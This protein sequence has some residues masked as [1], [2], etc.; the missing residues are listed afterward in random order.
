MTIQL[1]G[2]KQLD[3][4]VSTALAPERVWA[5]LMDARLLPRWAGP[6]DRIES[7]DLEG[8]RVGTVRDCRVHLGGRAGRIVERCVGLIPGQAIAY[9]VDDD[10]FGMSRM[11]AHYSFMISTAAGEAGATRLR[12]ETYYTPRNACASVMNALV[13]RRRFRGVVDELLAGLVRFAA[14]YE[15]SAQ[16]NDSAAVRHGVTGVVPTMNQ[17]T[18]KTAEE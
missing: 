4:E 13:L 10:S 15:P 7:C 14:E 2:T 18:P 11:L 9:A 3:R 1:Q 5:V 16:G 12:M 8:E 6:V 17:M